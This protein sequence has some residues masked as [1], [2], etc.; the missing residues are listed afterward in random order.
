MSRKTKNLPTNDTFLII[1]NGKKSEKNYFEIV[2]STY[3]SLYKITVSYMNEDPEGLIKQAVKVRSKFGRVWC[4]F[5]MDTFPE[6]SIYRSVKMAKDNDIDIA[7]SNV[8]F[9]VWL[10]YHFTKLDSEKTQKQLLDLL[11]HQ[12]NESGFS[13]EYIKGNSDVLRKLVEERMWDACENADVMYQ[14]R[15]LYYCDDINYQKNSSPI[16]DWNPYTT[17]HKLIEA[18]RIQK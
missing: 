14:K 4:V 16:C 6:D 1:T 2:R 11:A 17:V 9:E 13:K 3:T 8:S 18:L 7:F 10:I 12:L 15:M 5:D